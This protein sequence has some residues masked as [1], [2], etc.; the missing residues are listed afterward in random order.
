MTYNYITRQSH[1]GKNNIQVGAIN[2]LIALEI[3]EDYDKLDISS[4]TVKNIILERPDSTVLTF[5][6]SY[7]TDG[8]DGILYYRT[9]GSEILN[10]P[11]E[12]NVQAY[13]VMPDFTGY[14]TPV[15][16]PVYQNI[17]LDD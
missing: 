6:G 15:M 8:T 12:Y 13:L 11:G 7:L 1:A 4:A 3:R 5:S 10:Q 16:F 9:T 2:L 17:P 14:S